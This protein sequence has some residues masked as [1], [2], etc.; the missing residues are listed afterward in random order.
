MSDRSQR[1]C[2][3]GRPRGLE[4]RRQS[5]WICP[6]VFVPRT[7]NPADKPWQYAND[8][9]VSAGV[10]RNGGDGDDTHI[11]NECLRIGL[12][13]IKVRISDLLAELDAGHDKD[14]ELSELTERLARLQLQH[15]N[16]CFD[17]DRM[18]ERMRDLLAHKSDAADPEV[19]RMAEYEVGRAPAMK[20]GKADSNP[21][22]PR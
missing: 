20:S 14:A 15:H 5:W 16:V 2:T 3:C 19:V 9:L 6:T 11:C 22:V 21:G 4:Q 7:A 13:E 8:L 1:C 12:R 17:H 10:R 18:Q